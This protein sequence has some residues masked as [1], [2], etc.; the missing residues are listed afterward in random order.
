MSINDHYN[1]KGE[2]IEK[3]DSTRNLLKKIGITLC[4]KPES[5]SGNRRMLIKNGK[6]IGFY[7][8]DKAHEIF[9]K[10]PFN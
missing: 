4:T 1:D 8:A 10:K 3:P 6:K 2:F 9:I 5:K 7:S